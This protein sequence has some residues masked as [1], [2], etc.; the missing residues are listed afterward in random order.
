V[1]GG[2]PDHRHCPDAEDDPP[3]L[4]LVA[5]TLGPEVHDDDAQAVVGVIGDRADQ[6]HLAD[7]H[8]RVLVGADHRVVGLGGDPNE[9]RVEDVDEK[10]EE[11]GHAGDAMKNP[12]PH[13][14]VAAV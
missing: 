11:D 8:D 12:R 10:E 13:A 9:R 5:R 1:T 2:E 14:L 4:A 7:A 6:E 3:E